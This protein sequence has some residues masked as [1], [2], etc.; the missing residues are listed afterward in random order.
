MSSPYTIEI[1]EEHRTQFVLNQNNCVACQACVV[2][3]MLE[4]ETSPDIQWRGIFSFNEQLLDSL[5]LFHLSLAC[6]HCEDAPCMLN[7]PAIAYERDF[8]TGAVIHH[9]NKCIGCQYCIWVCPYDA[10]KFNPNTRVVEKCNFCVDRL[11]DNL[12]PA[13]V[14]SC[15]T[16]ALDIKQSSDKIKYSINT[17]FDDFGISPSIEIIP[18]SKGRT[19]PLEPN[20][21]IET[22]DIPVINETK[23]ITFQKEWPLAT[24]T[25]IAPLLIGLWVGMLKYPEFINKWIFASL[26]V[27]S[28]LMSTLHLGRKGRA[29][30]AILNLYGSWLSREILLWVIFSGLSIFY[31][32]IWQQLHIGLAGI[33]IGFIT[34]YTIDR[35]YSIDDEQGNL[36]LHSASAPLSGILFFGFASGF[37][38]F[39]HLILIIKAGLFIYRYFELNY[40]Q[41]KNKS[42]LSAFR[43]ILLLTGFAVQW[44]E[45]VPVVFLIS[46]AAGEFIDRAF[47]YEELDTMNPKRMIKESEL[48]FITKKQ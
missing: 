46:V 7:C 26:I 32:F 36:A 4:N 12:K 48:H 13:C 31:L 21:T 24:F 37:Y 5:P 29:Y 34:L 30:R 6:N 45:I 10:P 40:Y 1:T 39:A 19:K 20:E 2:A 23:H 14:T 16:G 44:Q 9:A 28:T 15:P 27:F 22:S 18:L 3:C 33:V 43:L 42:I 17:A 47:F 41:N 25:F 8:L 35:V 38:H 11:H